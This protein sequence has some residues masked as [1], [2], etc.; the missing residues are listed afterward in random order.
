MAVTAPVWGILGDRFGLKNMLTRA[1]IGGGVAMLLMGLV[2]T[3]LQLVGTRLFFGTVAG[4]PAAANAVVAAETPPDRVSRALGVMGSALPLGRSVGPLAGSVLAVFFTFRHIFL[5]TGVVLALAALLVIFEVRETPRARDGRGR[6]MGKLRQV[7]GGTRRALLAIVVAQGLVQW[8]ASSA[9]GMIGV[10]MLVLDPR[11]AAWDS[12]VAFAVMG[13][14]TA[15]S[16]WLYWRPARRLGLNRF[17]SACA[18]LF[19]LAVALLALAPSVIAVVVA[20]GALAVLTGAAVPAL[21]TM[22]G[23]EAPAGSKGTLFGWSGSS[24]SV[25]IAAGPA[26][27]GVIA[28]AAGV[29]VALLVSGITGLLAAGILV[30]WGREPESRAAPQAATA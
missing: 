11:H 19:V 9:Q 29:P 17:A 18:L 24:T 8:Q 5:A 27:T 10:R 28:A 7:D 12:G 21:S 30:A 14:C 23:L 3:P 25:G 15:A 2:V 20:N 6:A 4:A 1:F 16:S 13:L 26:L 22:L